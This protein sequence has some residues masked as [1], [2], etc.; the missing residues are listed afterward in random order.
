MH[1]LLFYDA[2]DNYEEAGS[3]FAQDASQHAREAAA[4]GELM[5]GGAFANP[6]DGARALVPR[7]L[8]GGGRALREQRSLRPE[9]AC[10]ENGVSANG[11]PSSATTLK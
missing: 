6:V 1:Y 3:H 11:R 4:R 8:A 7:R 5:L 10:H 9:R 2:I